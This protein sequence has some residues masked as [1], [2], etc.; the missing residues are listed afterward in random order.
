MLKFSG[1]FAVFGAMALNKV[2]EAAL[3]VKQDLVKTVKLKKEQP[4]KKVLD[5]DTFT[6]VNNMPLWKFGPNHGKCMASFE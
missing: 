1:F 4:A 5:E 3:A 6:E 2:G